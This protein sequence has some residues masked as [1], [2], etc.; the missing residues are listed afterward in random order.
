MG[1]TYHFIAGL[2]RSGST[3]LTAILNQNPSF[4]SNISDSLLYCI[5]SVINNLSS[6]QAPLAVKEE[7]AARMLIG[8]ID[9]FYFDVDK[10]SIFNANRGWTKHVEYLYR[11]NPNFKIICPVRNYNQILNSFEKNYKS[12][13]LIDP[14]DTVIYN[15]VTA[16]VWARTNHIGN[17]SFVMASYNFLKEAYY[18]PYKE[19]LL[20][21]E[22]EDL[23]KDPNN[24]LRKIYDFLEEPYFEHDFGYV[25][26]SNEA[27]D[28]K[29]LAHNLHKIEGPVQFKETEVVLPPE[30]WDAYSGMEFWRK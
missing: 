5:E 23:T 7:N 30:L 12:R 25:S 11:L 4:H 6:K 28:N 15:G 17:D 16:N 3:L 9:G 1:R 22:Y 24:T 19:H 26:Y 2:P 10:P 13:R 21:V 20:L 27:Y 14:V 8:L 18:G 29:L